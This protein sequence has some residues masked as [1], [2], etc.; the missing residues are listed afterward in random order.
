MLGQAKAAV[1]EGVG[2]HHVNTTSQQPAEVT[3]NTLVEDKRRTDCVF[4]VIS[5]PLTLQLRT[6]R[7]SSKLRHKANAHARTHRDARGRSMFTKPQKNC[8]DLQPWSL[9]FHSK[10]YAC[11]SP[12]LTGE[13][14][15]KRICIH[16]C[17]L[18]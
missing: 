2:E 13:S 5:P 10:L 18:N 9:L 1:P 16:T 6:T 8:D 3:G 4:F 12:T 14:S 7:C 11:S 17:M 15:R